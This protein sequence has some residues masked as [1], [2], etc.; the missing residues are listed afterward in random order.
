MEFSLE[1]KEYLELNRLIKYINWAQSGGEA[2]HL[3]TDGQ[4]RV[5]GE[6]ELRRRRKLRIGDIV[7]FDSKTCTVIK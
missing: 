7:T 2:N 1:E 5:N 6:K 4:L 3:V